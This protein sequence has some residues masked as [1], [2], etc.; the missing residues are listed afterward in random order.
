LKKYLEKIPICL[1]YS[2]LVLGF[3]LLALSFFKSNTNNYLIVAIMIWAI[4]SDI[5]DGII[6]RE[7]N[8]STQRLRRLD[9]SVDQIFWILSLVGAFILCRDF[10]KVHL[11]KI[12]I[13]LILE[14]LAYLISFIKFKKEVA[15]HAI[16]S[17]FWTL[18]IVSTLIQVILT[19]DSSVIFTTCFYLGVISRI[20]IISILLILKV[21]TNDVPSF[22][23][24]ILLRKGREIKR[25][26]LFNG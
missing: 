20:E 3:V 11:I 23:H 24:A 12:A 25:N 17:K 22:Y 1:I 8:V 21:W 4:V 6:A 19:C 16:L 9:S 13:I 14:G 15:T 26:K 10:F 5:F 18:T 7:L 2:R